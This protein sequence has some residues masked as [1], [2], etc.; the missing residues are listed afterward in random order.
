ML[1]ALSFVFNFERASSQESGPAGLGAWTQSNVAGMGDS[2]RVYAVRRSGALVV[3]G[4]QTQ[5]LFRSADSGVNWQQ[6]ASIPPPPTCATVAGRQR[7]PDRPAATYGSGLLRSTDGGAKLDDG[8]G[9]H[10]QHPFLQLRIVRQNTIYLG[11]ADRGVWRSVDN[12]A[13]LDGHGRARQPRRRIGGCGLRAGGLRRLGQ[14]RAVQEQQQRRKL[15]ADRL[16]GQDRAR[17]GAERRG[18][19]ALWQ[20]AR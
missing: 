18:Q 20:R 15:A 5:G 10:Q 16:C 9:Q 1:L 11:T 6:V 14:Q 3:A 8:R 2:T 4:T 19:P 12:G 7:R 13:N 17:A